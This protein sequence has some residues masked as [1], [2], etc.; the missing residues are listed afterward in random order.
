MTCQKRV[1]I[2]VGPRNLLDGDHSTRV[3]DRTFMAGKYR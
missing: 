2:K 1:G 3:T